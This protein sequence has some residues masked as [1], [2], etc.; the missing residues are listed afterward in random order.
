MLRSYNLAPFSKGNIQ[1]NML[2][3]SLNKDNIISHMKGFIAHHDS[4]LTVIDS[5]DY[6]LIGF[7]DKRLV[8]ETL[9]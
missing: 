6:G 8:P 1:D 5:C 2:I 7:N 3:G 9:S 4:C